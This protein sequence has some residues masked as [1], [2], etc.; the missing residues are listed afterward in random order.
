MLR[1]PLGETNTPR[2]RSS[3]LASVC[4]WAVLYCVLHHFRFNGWIYTVLQIR[5]APV[6]IKQGFYP[7]FFG[8]RFL[9]VERIA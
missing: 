3:L 1:T 9:A 5:L 4:P 7:A 2:L 6:V 8:R